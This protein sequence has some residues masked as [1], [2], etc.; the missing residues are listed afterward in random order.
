VTS[1]RGGLTY[2][3]V[4]TKFKIDPKLADEL[5]EIPK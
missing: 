2:T 5:F 1:E 3:A 4:H